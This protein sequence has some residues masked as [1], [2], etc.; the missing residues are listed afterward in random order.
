MLLQYCLYK[1]NKI[2]ISYEKLVAN[3]ALYCIIQ[4]HFIRP[5]QNPNLTKLL[6]DN[7]L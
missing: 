2:C 7:D 1:N 6:Y 5:E 4:S 3:T